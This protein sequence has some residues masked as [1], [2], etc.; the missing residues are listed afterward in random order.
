V[1]TGAAATGVTV[2]ATT[3]AEGSDKRLSMTAAG[4]SDGRPDTG[5][6]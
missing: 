5:A 3:A 1:I 2:E 4:D 6:E